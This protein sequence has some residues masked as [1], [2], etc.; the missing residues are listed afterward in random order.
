MAVPRQTGL[1][2][3]HWHDQYAPTLGGKKLPLDPYETSRSLAVHPNG[4]R[5]VLGTEW[6]LRAFDAQGTQLW[7]R[8]V[9]GI[10]WAVNVTGDGRLVVAAWP[11]RLPA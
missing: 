1:P 7:R 8:D 11:T 5:V 10:V 6:Y 4:D 9:P 2:V 3:E